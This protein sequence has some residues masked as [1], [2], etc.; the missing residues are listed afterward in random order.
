VKNLFLVAKL[1]IKES[2]RSKWFIVY[3]GIFGSLMALFFLTGI[4]DSVVMG[5]S[6]LSRLLLVYM[7]VTIVIL[8]ILILIFS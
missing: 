2:L 3:M 8:P 4:T 6:G 5:F 7:Q 1:D